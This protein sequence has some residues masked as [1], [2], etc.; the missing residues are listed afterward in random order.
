MGLGY[1]ILVETA[2]EVAVLSPAW[3]DILGPWAPVWAPAA[4]KSWAAEEGYVTL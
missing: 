4:G 3:A 2:N 1:L